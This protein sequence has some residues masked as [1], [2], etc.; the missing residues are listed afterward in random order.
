MKNA[1][2][3][4]FGLFRTIDSANYVFRLN[5][6]ATSTKTHRFVVA[7]RRILSK[8][9]FR[10]NETTVSRSMK[11][12]H[13]NLVE[14]PI[15]RRRNHENINSTCPLGATLA[16]ARCFLCFCVASPWLQIR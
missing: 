8:V 10:Y 15:L 1:E 4:L 12:L 2:N 9:L 16:R 7:K 14:E 6:T 5:E 13:T 3:L 11:A